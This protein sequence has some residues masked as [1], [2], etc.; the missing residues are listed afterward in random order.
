MISIDQAV[1]TCALL[2]G[3]PRFWVALVCCRGR[4]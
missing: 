2:T 1:V 4:Q 3:L